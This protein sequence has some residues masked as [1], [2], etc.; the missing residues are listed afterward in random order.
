MT[1]KRKQSPK[2]TT[3]E[4][5]SLFVPAI[6]AVASGFLALL[7]LRLANAPVWDARALGFVILLGGFLVVAAVVGGITQRAGNPAVR[8]LAASTA[9]LVG[10]GVL[11]QH[12][13]KGI[14]WDALTASDLGYLC[15]IPLAIVVALLLRRGRY[16][17]LSHFGAVGALVSVAGLVAL[18][19]VGTRF[20]GAVFYPGHMTPT[21]LLKPVLAL[22]L[23][24]VFQSVGA[25]R[26][27]A[28]RARVSPVVVWG[29]HGAVWGVLM[30]LL[31]Y[32]RDLGMLLILNAVLGS[33]AF[34]A[35]RRYGLAFTGLGV[36][37]AGTIAVLL[38]APHVRLRFDAWLDPFA[39]A[40]GKGWQVLQSL[41]ALYNGGLL[42]TGL[43]EGSPQAIP[44]ASSDF[45]YA[46]IGEELGL[47]GCA[48][49]LVVFGVLISAGFRIASSCK[50]PFGRLLGVGLTAS[51]AMQVILN[52]GGVTKAI[53]MT[54]VPLP[55]VSHGGMNLLVSFLM[56]GL[57]I[58]IGAPPGKQAGRHKRK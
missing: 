15:G 8:A 49:M 45:I 11:M 48:L 42:G 14:Q 17:L 39:S 40:T 36:A 37:V 10:V 25:R 44:V 57:L 5:R 3:P 26:K 7:A 4:Q 28:S 51:I 56:I 55:F 16:R 13:V 24:S 41:S 43:G 6:L 23:A 50:E 31:A 18:V 58:A 34:V 38:F 29:W 1:A 22:F 47:L 19:A 9:F 35:L 21:E 33:I 20:R 32:Q 46:A 2:R 12:R 30:L 54:G 27:P 53:P 52:V